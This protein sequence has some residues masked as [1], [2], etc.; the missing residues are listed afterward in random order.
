[1]RSSG[2]FSQTLQARVAVLRGAGLQMCHPPK[3]QQ[4]MAWKC[5]DIEPEENKVPDKR[6]HEDHVRTL[7]TSGHA[8]F[9]L[10]DGILL[11]GRPQG[12]NM[13]D[14]FEVS[15]QKAVAFA[16]K[17]D[18]SR[19]QG[20]DECQELVELGILQAALIIQGRPTLIHPSSL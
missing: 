3:K 1:M 12:K 16:Y 8:I 6:F 15:F 20:H 14:A 19:L 11:S 17:V 4:D 13:F 5:L 18:S 10:C 9:L 7:P 2:S